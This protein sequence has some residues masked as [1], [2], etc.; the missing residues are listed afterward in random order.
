MGTVRGA[1]GDWI[2]RTARQYPARLALAGFAV[3]IG[4]FTLL[5][6]LPLA[7]QDRV[8]A[9]FVD[10]LFTATSAVCVTGLT[11][12]EVGAYWSFFG[13]AVMLI[14]IKVGG[15]M[16]LASIIGL[17]V[18]RRLGLTQRLLAADEARASG[19]GEFRSLLRTIIIVS[20]ATELAIAFIL[21]WRLLEH[22]DNPW[23][24]AWH[25]LF[26]GVSSFNNAGFSPD[27]G[28]VVP[29]L[30][31]P[32]FRIPIAAG[33][34]IGALGFPVYLNLI[35]AWRKPRSWTLHTKITL[36]MIVV[37]TFVSGTLLAL[38]EWRNP[39]PWADYLS[40][41]RSIRRRSCP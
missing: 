33:V 1:L 27:I 37:L 35:R 10:A 6:E 14:A 29:F 26:Y 9:P 38:F 7:T 39:E 3:A 16:T 5:L 34:F 23:V 25:S 41:R 2:E 30:G 22:H 8:R 15:I 18:S 11:P 13:Q 32:L 12:V 31:D 21:F 19:L 40:T 28:G 17:A 4:I 24:A 36:Y 20:T